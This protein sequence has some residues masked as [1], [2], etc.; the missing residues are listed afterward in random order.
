MTFQQDIER[1]AMQK[2]A[3]LSDM[4]SGVTGSQ[5]TLSPLMYGLGGAA[6]G[7]L[8][9]ASR[10]GGLG[11]LGGAALG[12][13]GGY[14]IANAINTQGANQDAVDSTLIGNAMMQGQGMSQTDQAQNQMLQSI[15]DYLS[16]GQEPAQDP[17][18]M[19]QD[20]YAQGGQKMSSA[21]EDKLISDIA[22]RITAKLLNR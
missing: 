12:G 19:S 13:L 21:N 3:G 16:S 1:R 8:G 4:L 22:D 20:P 15:V 5:G 10:L 9:G 18:A 14:G 11:M 7:G 2:I 6:L 17:N